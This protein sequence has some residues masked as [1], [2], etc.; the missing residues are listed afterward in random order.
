MR[1]FLAV[2]LALVSVPAGA[3]DALLSGSASADY[4][5]VSGPNPP[6]NPSPFGINGLTLEV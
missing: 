3:F 4:R 5:F 6:Q 1:R 2:T